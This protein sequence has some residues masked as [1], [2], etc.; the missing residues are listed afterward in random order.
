MSNGRFIG[1]IPS[2]SL[3]WLR[4]R[5]CFLG[6][7]GQAGAAR[8]RRRFK[9]KK[10]GVSKNMDIPFFLQDK[11]SYQTKQQ[12]NPCQQ[13]A[14]FYSVLL[15]SIIS[16]T[17]SSKTKTQPN[18][19]FWGMQTEYSV[20]IVIMRLRTFEI[21]STDRIISQTPHS[22][23]PISRRHWISCDNLPESPTDSPG[24]LR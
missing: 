8:L 18:L 22:L 17:N 19:K 6:N 11:S 15:Y 21:S 24:P 4:C 9:T 10:E 14:K 3:F 16:I 12:H 2:I 1:P 5:G 13:N 20:H 7:C 23:P